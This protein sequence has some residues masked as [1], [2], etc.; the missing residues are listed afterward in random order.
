MSNNTENC[1]LPKTS[2]HNWLLTNLL[3][4]QLINVSKHLQL[5]NL[6]VFTLIIQN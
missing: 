5:M 2:I 4:V 6:F 1:I 3:Q